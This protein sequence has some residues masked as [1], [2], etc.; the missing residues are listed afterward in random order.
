[1]EFYMENFPDIQK[2][3]ELLFEY[4][5]VF[6]AYSIKILLMNVSVE[7]LRAHNK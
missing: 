1:M 6:M 2:P 4:N 5:E 7:L 3:V